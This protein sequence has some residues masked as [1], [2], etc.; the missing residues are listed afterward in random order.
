[1]KNVREKAQTM[2]HIHQNLTKKP[3]SSM[4]CGPVL[5][6]HCLLPFAAL[7]LALAACTGR[8]TE[9]EPFPTP[10]PKAAIS[11]PAAASPTLASSSISTARWIPSPQTSFQIQ[12]SGEFDPG[13]EADLY[14]LDLFD[15]DAS[16]VENLHD[17][18]RKVI[19]YI[20]AGSFEDWRPDRDRFPGSV[21]GKEYAGWPGE[22]W[23]DIRQLDLIGPILQARLDQCQSKGFDGV[24]FD[25]VNGFENDT[26]FP[27]T[28]Q[29]QI[30]FNTWLATEARNREMAVGLKNDPG[31]AGELW[32]AFDFAIV[33]SCFSE[34]WCDQMRPFFDRG[35]AVFAI[36]YPE[37]EISF[38]PFCSQAREMQISLIFK[39]LSLD[40]YRVACP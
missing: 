8:V 30:T 40:A 24:E 32:P 13:V 36:E 27:L 31:Q 14:D 12:F 2:L 18:G 28:A 11:L 9:P 35:K 23:L 37:A 1:L 16:V 7:S 15:T 3:P 20:D 26:G 33:E 22:N 21:I 29:D 38:E 17:L 19:C 39:H 25:N 5:A 4:D 34:G 10:S 6:P